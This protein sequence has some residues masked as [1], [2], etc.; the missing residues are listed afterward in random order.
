MVQELELVDVIRTA[1]SAMPDDQ[2]ATKNNLDEMNHGPASPSPVALVAKDAEKR[3]KFRMVAII[4]ALFVCIHPFPLGLL[5]LSVLRL[6]EIFF[7]RR[8]RGK[9]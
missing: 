1:E 8:G 9:K 7:M 5:L 4:T 6:S 2:S 3:S